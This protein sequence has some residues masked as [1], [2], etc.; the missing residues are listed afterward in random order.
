MSPRAVIFKTLSATGG[1]LLVAA[2]AAMALLAVLPGPPEGAFAVAAH[3]FVPLWV[4]VACVLP[5]VVPN[6]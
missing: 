3:L 1:A 4:V 2:A 6:R 5:L